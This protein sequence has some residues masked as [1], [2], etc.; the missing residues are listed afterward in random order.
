[1]S[2]IILASN[3][4][5]RKELLE[6]EQIPFVVE[7]SDID[8]VLDE[9]LSVEERLKKLA[10]SKGMPI[11]KKHPDDIVISADTTCYHDGKIIGKA[12]SRE[13]AKKMLESFSDDVQIVYTAVAIFFPNETINFIDA[14]KVVFKDITDMIED[15][16]DTNEWVNKAG[17][18]AIQL[19]GQMFIKEV[20]GDV[21]TVIGLPV[22]KVKQ[23][24]IDHHAL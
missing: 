24:L 15:Y 8:E 16:L 23:I 6:R 14:T 5:R 13:E 3:S 12:H 11:H 9:N 10:L 2:K 18:Y 17:A 1:M 21:D 20:D 22:K 19:K 4:P 7:A